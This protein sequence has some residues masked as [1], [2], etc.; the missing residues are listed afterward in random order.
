[1]GHMRKD[2]GA[3]FSC[4]ITSDISRLTTHTVVGALK[5]ESTPTASCLA[6]LAGGAH[7]PGGDV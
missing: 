6:L 5:G 7:G 2:T 4:S 3:R 1:M